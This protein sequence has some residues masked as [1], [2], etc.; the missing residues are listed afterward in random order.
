MRLLF[1]EIGVQITKHIDILTRELN[2][3][4]PIQVDLKDPAISAALGKLKESLES[5]V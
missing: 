4:K 3:S 5:Y 2:N 1:F